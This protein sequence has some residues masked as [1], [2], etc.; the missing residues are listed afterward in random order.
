M[1]DRS[2]RNDNEDERDR[3]CWQIAE[4]LKCYLGNH[5]YRI[6]ISAYQTRYTCTRCGH[7]FIRSDVPDD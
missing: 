6:A 2:D 5:A 3:I 1:P 4:G 7:T